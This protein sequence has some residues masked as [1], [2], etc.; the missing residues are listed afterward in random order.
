MKGKDLDHCF[1][2]G[3]KIEGDKTN[4]AIIQGIFLPK[5]SKQGYPICPREK[6]SYKMLLSNEIKGK[7]LLKTN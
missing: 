2:C 6:C 3:A 7:F 5:G 1:S 4:R